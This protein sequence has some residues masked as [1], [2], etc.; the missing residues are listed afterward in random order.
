MWYGWLQRI[1]T[2]RWNRISS[3]I[4]LKALSKKHAMNCDFS[5]SRVIFNNKIV[6]SSIDPARCDRA[7]INQLM[8]KKKYDFSNFQ[9]CIVVVFLSVMVCTLQAQSVK[10]LKNSAIKPFNCLSRQTKC[11]RDK[12]RNAVHW[13]NTIINKNIVER[14]TLINNIGRK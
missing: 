6:F 12:N 9:S 10:S 3:K 8:K 14:K 2:N 7:D 11:W 13:I 5:I 1:F 4:K